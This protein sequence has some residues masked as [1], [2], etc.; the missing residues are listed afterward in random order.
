M[1][2][3][4]TLETIYWI[5][6]VV[7][8]ALSGI[9]FKIHCRSGVWLS[10]FLT[11]LAG[12]L[13]LIILDAQP[14]YISPTLYFLLLTIIFLPGPLLLGYVG[15]ISSRRYV[16]AKDFLPCLLPVLSVIAAPSQISTSGIFEL[17]SAEEYQRDTYIGLFNLLSAVAGALMLSYVMMSGW[18]IW[19]ARKDWASYQSKTLPSEWYKMLLVLVVILITTVAQITSSFIHP[20]GDSAS[21]GDITFILFVLFFIALGGLTSYEKL[22]EHKADDPIILSI[23]ESLSADDQTKK[24]MQTPLD[25]KK[26]DQYA[27]D[28]LERIKDEVLF[29]Q[30]DLSLST[31]ATQLNTTPHK[32]SDLLNTVFNCSFYELINDLRVQYAAQKLLDDRTRSIT[33][34]FFE[35]GFTTKSTFYSYFK[36]TFGCTP[37]EYRK[38]S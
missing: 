34:V 15:H 8:L 19:R 10:A 14:F 3:E 38:Q 21:L 37:T 25:Q 32:L 29:L 11:F 16:N 6:T 30:A 33:D 12:Y 17:S 9:L 13:G 22:V 35:A 7:C 24:D 26:I 23:E 5:L 18:L 1:S 4:G 28:T 36:K 2:G 31:L 20:S 27:N